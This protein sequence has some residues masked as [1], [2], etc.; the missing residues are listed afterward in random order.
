M[1]DVWGY[2]ALGVVGVLAVAGE[3]LQQQRAQSTGVQLQA[4]ST[5]AATATAEAAIAQAQAQA[6][7]SQQAVVDRLKAGTF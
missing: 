4:A 2:L 7:A 3:W 1:S 5:T 6:P